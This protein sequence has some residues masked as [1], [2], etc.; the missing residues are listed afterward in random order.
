LLSSDFKNNIDVISSG[1]LPEAGGLIL[2]GAS[3]VGKSL[4]TLEWSIKLA[5]R[6]PVIDFLLKVPIKRKI[7]IFQTEIPNSYMQKRTKG[8]LEG[9]AIENLPESIFFADPAESFDLKNPEC[10]QKMTNSIKSCGADVFVIDPLS[11]FHRADENNNSQMRTIMDNIRRISLNTGAA[12]IIV[13]HFGKPVDKRYEGYRLRGASSIVD[14][15]DTVIT[16]NPKDSA[17]PNL[18][19]LSFEKVRHGEKLKPIRLERDG[20]RFFYSR[21][22]PDLKVTPEKV[23][24]ILE[25]QF[26]GTAKSQKELSIA[27]QETCDCVPRT[28]S[29]GIKKAVDTGVI[30]KRKAGKRMEYYL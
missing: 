25:D 5:L 12:S 22:E 8:M 6:E 26:D 1:I 23:K 24:R 2:A 18:M 29:D 4:I 16:I 9:L 15:A 19:N 3:G 28:A 13:H 20:F 10:I 27:I 17:N 21:V 11:S 14:W 30:R 7:V